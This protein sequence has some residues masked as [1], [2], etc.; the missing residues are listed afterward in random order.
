MREHIEHA[1]GDRLV[2]RHARYVS[3]VAAGLKLKQMIDEGK[4]KPD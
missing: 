2:G 4:I 1:R 3:G